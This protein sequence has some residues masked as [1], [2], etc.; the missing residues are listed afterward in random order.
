M[1]QQK[2]D[3]KP[4]TTKAVA[5]KT[6]DQ[7]MQDI[8]REKQAVPLP[9]EFQALEVVRQR[10]REI[11]EFIAHGLLEKGVDYGRIPGVNKDMLFK[12]GCEMLLLNYKIAVDP[13]EIEDRSDWDRGIFRY[14]I[15]LRGY[16]K[17]DRTYVGM[18]VASC[19]SYEAKYRYRWLASYQ[20]T[21]SMRKLGFNPKTSK[22]DAELL[23]DIWITQHG[24]NAFRFK[25]I[26]G[27]ATPQWRIENPDI[28]DLEN[29]ILKQSITRALRA[30]TLN[31]TGADRLFV[32]E[33]DLENLG[34]SEIDDSDFVDGEYKE[35]PAEEAPAPVAEPTP[36]PAPIEPEPE[37]TPAPIETP[38]P[39]PANAQQQTD[40]QIKPSPAPLSKPSMEEPQ[41]RMCKKHG[42]YEFKQYRTQ[43]GRV[44]WAHKVGKDGEGNDVWCMEE[45]VEREFAQKQQPLPETTAA[46]AAA[47]AGD[48]GDVDAID[49]KDDNEFIRN[50][51]EVL[52]KLGWKDGE[53]NAF[54]NTHY[55]TSGT[56]K[57]QFPVPV[58]KPMLKDLYSILKSKTNS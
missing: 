6:T 41:K 58:R 13:P 52:G 5:K 17:D 32:N 49:V 45:D 23:K 56:D 21:D 10:V 42:G 46:A 50:L 35:M 20:L 33:R 53:F 18:G 44:V 28:Y 11:R 15:I 22:F 3:P 16:N 36:E 25:M 51:N 19:S 40:G 34:L 30:L 4:N 54:I 29:T 31:V 39:T 57:S 14:R 48:I 1:A 9:A 37:P 7:E 8:A 47:P 55:P 26:N 24:D 27:K 12:A 38:A 2:Q 43:N